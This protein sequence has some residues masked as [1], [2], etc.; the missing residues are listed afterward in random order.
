MVATYMT[1]G[2]GDRARN[3]GGGDERIYEIH[4]RVAQRGQGGLTGGGGE[5]YP[6]TNGPSERK[7]YCRSAFGRLQACQCQPWWLEGLQGQY[8]MLVSARH[9]KGQ[10]GGKLPS[11]D[12]RVPEAR[13]T[14]T[15]NR[16]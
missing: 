4:G 15:G 9:Q 7:W 10:A 6:T 8:G 12:A 13:P 3:K 11:T 1:L 2:K 14:F 5:R 16:S